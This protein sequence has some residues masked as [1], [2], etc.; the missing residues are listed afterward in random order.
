MKTFVNLLKLDIKLLTKHNL[1]AVS[2][3]L[4]AFYIVLF[5]IFNINNYYPLISATIFS[6]PSMLGFIFI[7]VM[8]L[9]EKGQ[10]TLQAI[11]VCPIKFEYYIWSKAIAMTIM[12]LPICFGIIFSAHGFNFNYAAFILGVILTSLLFSLLGFIGVAHVQTFNQYIII[13]PMFFMP[14]IIPLFDSFNLWFH[15]LFY[16]IPSQASLLLFRATFE[17]LSPGEWIYSIV[18]L[19][20]WLA[21]ARYFAIK[22]YKKHLLV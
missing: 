19:I 9:Y 3:F 10:H 5:K 6:D 20:A 15:P 21:G 2:L 14:A 13:I 16:L 1:L 8:V 18:Y 22:A 12:A 17:K 7:G 11:S 4:A